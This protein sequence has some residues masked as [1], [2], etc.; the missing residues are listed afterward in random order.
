[1][2]T[3][4]IVENGV[5]LELTEKLTSA[6]ELGLQYTATGYGSKIPTTHVVSYKGRI[7]RIYSTGYFNA[8]TNWFLLD[9]EKVLVR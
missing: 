2:R 1:M 6:Q 7:R 9:G 4:I 5:E 3:V 8:A